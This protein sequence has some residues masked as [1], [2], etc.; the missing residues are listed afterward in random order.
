MRLKM[1][2][3]PSSSILRTN[4]NGTVETTQ[5]IRIGGVSLAPGT[6]LNPGQIIAGIDLTQYPRNDF[7]IDVKDGVLV[8]T[9]IYGIGQ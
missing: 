9:G 8:I 4:A 6:I 3:I 7:E 1:P 2:R 5:L